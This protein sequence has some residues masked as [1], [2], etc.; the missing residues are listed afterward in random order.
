[1][2]GTAR[3]TT[4]GRARRAAG[5]G[6]LLLVVLDVAALIAAMWTSSDVHVPGAS[7]EVDEIPG[8]SL[9]VDFEIQPV[10]ALVMWVALSLVVLLVLEML[11]RGRPRPT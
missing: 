7:I 9:S 4:V 11:A 2:T 3:A 1:M 10:A 8:T 5:V 6:L